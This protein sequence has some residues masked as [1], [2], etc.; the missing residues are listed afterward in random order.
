MSSILKYL[1]LAII[2]HTSDHFKSPTI[3][4]KHIV[5]PASSLCSEWNPRWNCTHDNHHLVFAPLSTLISLG[6]VNSVLR[7]H[8]VPNFR[9]CVLILS[10]SGQF[11]LQIHYSLLVLMKVG[12]HPTVGDALHGLFSPAGG[13]LSTHPASQWTRHRRG[14]PWRVF[15][16]SCTS[17][18]PSEVQNHQRQE[19]HGQ[20]HVSHL[21]PSPGERGRQEGEKCQAAETVNFNN[22]NST[23]SNVWSQWL[24]PFLKGQMVFHVA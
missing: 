9:R 10:P 22:E 16:A 17:G 18:G 4:L 15:P 3:P 5:F 7:L 19:G 6:L 14:W 11:D 2:S 24:A 13:G 8:Q 23:N 1:L 21:L 12:S 20:R